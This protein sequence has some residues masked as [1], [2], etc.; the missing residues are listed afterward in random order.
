MINEKQKAWIGLDP[1][2]SGAYAI[3][4]ESGSIDVYDWTDAIQFGEDVAEWKE[5]LDVR[6]ATIEAV[7]SMPGQGVSSSFK[8]GMVYGM[9]QGVVMANKL[10]ILL[11]S[12]QKWQKAMLTV[13]DGSTTKEQSLYAARRAFP[14]ADIRLKKHHGRADAAL[15][16]LYGKLNGGER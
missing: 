1:G 10:P 3:L 12:P 16:A 2:K 14:N 6:L 4:R 5:I 7:H 9:A 13:A 11:V 8:F 15:L